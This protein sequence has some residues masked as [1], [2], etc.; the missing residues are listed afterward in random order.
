MFAIVIDI[1]SLNQVLNYL[2][3]GGAGDKKKSF[4]NLFWIVVAH[5]K[6]CGQVWPGVA[7]CGQVWPG[8]IQP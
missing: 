7:R 5:V 2:L 3:G 4:L 8:V 6:R 1:Q